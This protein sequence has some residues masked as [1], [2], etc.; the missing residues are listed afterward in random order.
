M[1][2]D[3]DHPD[4][5]EMN[6]FAGGK[7]DPGSFHAKVVNRRLAK[8][9]LLSLDIFPVKPDDTLLIAA[10]GVHEVDRAEDGLQAQD[11]V[12]AVLSC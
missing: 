6:A 8:S 7:F 1:L 3:P 9:A 12:P 11:A 10:C 2:V 4:Y 5:R